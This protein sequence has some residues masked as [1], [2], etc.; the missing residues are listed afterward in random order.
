MALLHEGADAKAAD[1]GRRDGEIA[2]L[3]GVE[4]LGLPI[5]HDGAHQHADCSAVRAR[6]ICGRISPS[7]LMAGGKPAVMKRSEA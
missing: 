2:L 5:I 3:G 6:S 4:F 7:I 1:A